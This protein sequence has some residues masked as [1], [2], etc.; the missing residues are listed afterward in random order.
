MRKKEDLKTNNLLTATSALARQSHISRAQGTTSPV[1]LPPNSL[2]LK[3]QTPM[4]RLEALSRLK[5]QAEPFTYNE[6]DSARSSS[7]GGY[8]G[9]LTAEHYR[10]A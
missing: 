8:G 7:F 2:R 4:L 1:L 10:K 9:L 3:T 6:S 5:P